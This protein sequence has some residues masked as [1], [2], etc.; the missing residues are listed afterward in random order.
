M[1]SE[2]LE[3]GPALEEPILILIPV[4][5]DWSALGKLLDALDDTLAE[6]DIEAGVLVVDD[7]ST[8]DPQVDP[9]ARAFRALR[10]VEILELR[11]NLGH[12]RAIAIGLAYVEDRGSCQ[13]VVV[14]DGDGEDNPRDVPRLLAKSLMEGGTKIVFAERTRRSE[15]LVFRVFYKLY[16]VVHLFLTG[17]AVRVGNF[18]VIP[19]PRLASL[20]VVSEMWNHYAA[21]AF[22]SRQP[23]TTVPTHRAKRIDGKSHMNFVNLVVH[24]LSAISVYGEL[25]GIRL[26]VVT[27]LMVLATLA[28]L[29][30][31]VFVRLATTWAI[32]GW[33]TTAVGILLVILMQALM[34][35]LVF[36]FV[37]LGGRQGSAFLPRRDYAYFI[38]RTSGRTAKARGL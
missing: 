5:N 16:K 33:A 18:S 13:A 8:V 32:P 38:G 4:F 19:R 10:H 29:A 20:V 3:V 15:S 26:L 35:S 11:R 22:K 17:Y 21:A 23:Y 6:N 24:G 9:T 31:V 25:V 28:G 2:M 37:I 27:V 12:Q 1:T 36:S 30:G 7:G 14:M 34:L